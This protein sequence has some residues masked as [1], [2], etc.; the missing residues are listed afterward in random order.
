MW[1]NSNAQGGYLWSVRGGGLCTSSDLRAELRDVGSLA[2]QAPQA[3]SGMLTTNTYVSVVRNLLPGS[4]KFH[5][6]YLGHCLSR[7]YLYRVFCG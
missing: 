6:Y 7:G 1:R 4:A 2:K 3:G 5:R